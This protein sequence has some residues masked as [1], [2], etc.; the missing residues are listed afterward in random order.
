MGKSTA[1]ALT[2]PIPGNMPITV[3]RK[4]PNK[5]NRIFWKV[6][7]VV[8]PSKSRWIDSMFPPSFIS[9]RG[10]DLGKSPAGGQIV[11]DRGERG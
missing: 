2:G 7:A 1:M 4:T 10:H 5:T 6:R 3:P 9:A 8:K 11:I